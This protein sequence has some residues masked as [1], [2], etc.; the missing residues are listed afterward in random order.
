MSVLAEVDLLISVGLIGEYN[1]AG[2]SR[3]LPLFHRWP[4]STVVVN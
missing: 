1:N 3:I 4:S 2:L